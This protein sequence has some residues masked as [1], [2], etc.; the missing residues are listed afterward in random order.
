MYIFL[1]KRGQGR[2]AGAAEDHMKCLELLGILISFMEK[3]E[4]ILT[5]A[6]QHLS[7]LPVPLLRQVQ[8]ATWLN[9]DV[10]IAMRILFREIANGIA[11]QSQ[12]HDYH[13]PAMI[14][15]VH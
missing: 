14:Y 4:R 8:P 7:A 5:A 2:A 6:L 13:K 11:N 12:V 1:I 9:Q 15:R 3:G 10:R